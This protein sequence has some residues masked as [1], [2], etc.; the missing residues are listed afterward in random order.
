VGSPCVS[1]TQLILPHAWAH[2]PSQLRL[3]ANL[4]QL[5]LSRDFNEAGESLSL[6]HLPSSIHT[7]TLGGVMKG[8]DLA[9]LTLPHSLT[10][11]DLLSSCNASLDDIVWPPHLTRLVTGHAF[12][13]PL[14]NWSPPASLRELVL[15]GGAAFVGGWNHP[16][17]RL[18][19]PSNLVKLS[20][21]SAFNHP[22]TDFQFPV[23]L[24]AL[25]FGWLFNQ[26]LARDAW[27][28]PS[29]LEELHLSSRWDRPCTGMHLPTTLRK[30]TMPWEFNQPVENERGECILHLPDTLTELRFGSTFNQSLRNLRLPNSLRFLSLQ[31]PH[32]DTSTNLNRIQ[33][34]LSLP[35]GLQCLEVY[36]ESALHAQGWAQHP[37]WSTLIQQC[38]ISYVEHNQHHRGCRA[39]CWRDD[40]A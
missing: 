12:N 19:L 36:N 34:P 35:P 5:R 33:P 17:S 1:L 31:R 16:V 37:Q 28:P 26:S 38:A 20:F 39:E 10:S 11:L 22:L 2:G 8:N 21:G 3:P 15:H 7:L 13:Q 30:L 9:A 23:S 18:R 24:R 6:L 27:S 32:H 14:L 40:S 4:T 25:Q 29:N